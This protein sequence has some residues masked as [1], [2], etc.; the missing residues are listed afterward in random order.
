LTAEPSKN[1]RPAQ[2]L[3][4][5]DDRRE[6][7][8]PFKHVLVV[9]D[10]RPVLI[11]LRRMLEQISLTV[12]TAE[13]AEEAL[14]YLRSHRPDLIFMD[15]ILPGM[16]GLDATKAIAADPATAAIP[17]VM[18]SSKNGDAFVKQ[19]QEHGA[20]AVLP[21]PAKPDTLAKTLQAL[22]ARAGQAVGH[23]NGNGA[24]SS[25]GRNPETVAAAPAPPPGMTP[26][27]VETLARAAAESVVGHTVQTVVTRLLEDQL[28]QLKQDLFTRGRI[29]AKE[30]AN[31]VYS[32][33]MT[34][35][36]NQFR[37][38]RREVDEQLAALKAGLD[39][40]RPS[41]DT[42]VR[43]EIEQL[44]RSV[45]GQVATQSA[46]E[47]AQTVARGL[48]QAV[49][50]QTAQ[51]VAR[52]VAS[53]T[54]AGRIAELSDE[55]KQL[56]EQLARIASRSEEPKPL[57]AEAR[58][59]VQQLARSVAAQCIEPATQAAQ[60]AARKSALAVAEK[61]AADVARRVVDPLI[62]AVRAQNSRM[63]LLA[64]TAMFVGILAAAAA[65][66]LE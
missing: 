21:K 47:S 25:G 19:A 46:T 9:D 6:V 10:S 22:N 8:M 41:I 34:E 3:L 27:A 17:V 55:L 33:R 29:A 63:Y 45:A 31:E 40:T 13:S 53:E 1:W 50:E 48:A 30:I 39:S 32:G 65:Y 37:Q 57:S 59:D 24:T 4:S 5:P 60:K 62:D 36:S 18:H 44:A 14:D 12:D 56:R 64:S 11:M 20:A 7:V 66:L 58:E 28:S 54:W 61:T 23:A 43:M 16:S 42:E 49:A 52:A 35:V 26:A 2:K 15:H 38:V 51:S